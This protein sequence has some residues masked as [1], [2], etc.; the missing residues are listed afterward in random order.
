VLTMSMMSRAG[1][2]EML[3]RMSL[4]KTLPSAG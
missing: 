1:R 3:R 4:G 2:M